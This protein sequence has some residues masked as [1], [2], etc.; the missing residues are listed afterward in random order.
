MASGFWW[1]EARRI[2]WLTSI[3]PF[4]GLGVKGRCARKL[5]D[6]WWASADG[7]SGVFR[8]GVAGDPVVGHNG[9]EPLRCVG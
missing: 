3:T 2:S 6:A 4:A 8:A 7:E 9:L 5:L 1:A